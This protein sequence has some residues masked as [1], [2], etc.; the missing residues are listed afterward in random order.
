M[1]RGCA[2]VATVQAWISVQ[3]PLVV[4]PSRRQSSALH[5]WSSQMAFLAPTLRKHPSTGQP[6]LMQYPVGRWAGL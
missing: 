4:L 3:Y 6:W 1:L 2:Q 5:S